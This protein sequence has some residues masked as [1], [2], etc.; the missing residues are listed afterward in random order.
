MKKVI[1]SLVLALLL[2]AVYLTITEAQTVA[3]SPFDGD[4]QDVPC[5]RV[6]DGPNC[7][8]SQFGGDLQDVSY[9]RV[10]G[11]PNCRSAAI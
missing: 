10:C 9:L 7:V 1:S 6:C 2:L 11:G 4:L 8:R 5:L 3:Q